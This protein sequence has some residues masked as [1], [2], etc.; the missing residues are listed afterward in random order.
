[1][2]EGRDGVRVVWLLVFFVGSFFVGEE[3]SFVGR[4]VVVVWLLLGLEGGD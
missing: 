1:M 4:R 2:F 3:R